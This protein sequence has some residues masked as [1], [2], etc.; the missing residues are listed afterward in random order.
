M[1]IKYHIFTIV[2]AIIVS[3]IILIPGGS[4]PNLEF[5]NLLG[6]DKLVHF[7]AFALLSLLMIV[8]FNKQYSDGCYHFNIYYLTIFSLISYGALLE[9]IQ[10]YIPDRN[11]EIWDA[12]ANGL[13]VIFGRFM[14][15]MIYK[16]RLI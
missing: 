11:F 10:Q 5:F 15:F 4:L 9:F 6:F 8:G 7:F 2:W 1:T 13:G 12:V 14:F 3:S 16:T